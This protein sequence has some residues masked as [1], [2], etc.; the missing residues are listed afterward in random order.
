MGLYPDWPT[1]PIGD[2]LAGDW[3][4]LL[5]QVEAGAL[6]DLPCSWSREITPGR[7]AIYWLDTAHRTRH[8]VIGYGTCVLTR[9]IAMKRPRGRTLH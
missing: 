4:W 1:W 9:P 6:P 8:I 3:Q 7:C 2:A 5:Q